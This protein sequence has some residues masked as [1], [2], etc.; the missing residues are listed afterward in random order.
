MD[1]SQIQISLHTDSKLAS[2]S[3]TKQN[4]LTSEVSNFG[5]KVQFKKIE[6]SALKDKNI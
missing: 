5:E 2:K 4:Q 3:N 1:L 6:E